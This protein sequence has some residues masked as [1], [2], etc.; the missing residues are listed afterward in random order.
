MAKKAPKSTNINLEIKLHRGQGLQDY[1]VR[2]YL[3]RGIASGHYR[4]S[5]DRS[6][7]R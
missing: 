2:P 6:Q 1:K 4:R 3:R 5:L 7:D